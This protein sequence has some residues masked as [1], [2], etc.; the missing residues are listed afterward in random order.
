MSIR[1]IL[2]IALLLAAAAAPFALTS[3]E[4][5]DPMG[6]YAFTGKDKAGV[7]WT[8]TLII[9]QVDTS[10]FD[11]QKF[12]FGAHLDISNADGGGKGMD[13]CVTFDL[14]TRLVTIGADSKYGGSV[15]TATLSADGTNLAD[16]KWVETE[17]SS[18]TGKRVAS[19][20][21]WTASKK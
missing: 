10:M 4:A 9:G 15:Y 20:G 16:G 7:E 2:P 6:T 21:T 19:E 18:D 14:E 13:T 17:W 1:R 8:G 5:D 11:P 3:S 12:P